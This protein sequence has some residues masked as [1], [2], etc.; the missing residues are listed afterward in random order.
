MAL[1]ACTPTEAEEEEDPDEYEF[2]ALEELP[3]EEYELLAGAAA[4]TGWALYWFAVWTAP[5][6]EP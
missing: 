5:E 3:P 1:T 6:G 4:W 2:P